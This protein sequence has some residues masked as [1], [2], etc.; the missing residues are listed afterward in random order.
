MPNTKVP[1]ALGCCCAAATEVSTASTRA[2]ARTKAAM[3]ANLISSM[4][5]WSL[6]TEP[7]DGDDAMWA[8]TLAS[9]ARR[10]YGEPWQ[11]PSGKSALSRRLVKYGF[12]PL[13][14]RFGAAELSLRARGRQGP[15]DL[16]RGGQGHHRSRRD[17]G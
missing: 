6:L 2:T 5:V 8:S 12:M 17:L 14:Q 3:G 13:S 1:P 4:P 7:A 15:Q 9:T 10:A 16:S 11:V